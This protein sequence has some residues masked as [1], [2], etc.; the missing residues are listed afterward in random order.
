MWR[1]ASP[2]GENPARQRLIGANL[3]GKIATVVK[4]F[5]YWRKV[6]IGSH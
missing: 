6:C 1:A 2:D 3:V 4:T 5:Y